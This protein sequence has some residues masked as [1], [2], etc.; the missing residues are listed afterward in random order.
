MK[1]NYLQF[2][3]IIAVFLGSLFIACSKDEPAKIL[4]PKEQSIEKLTANTWVLESIMNAGADVTDFHEELGLRNSVLK[5]SKSYEYTSEP[6]SRIFKNRGSWLLVDD[7]NL[8]LNIA[9]KYENALFINIIKG[10]CPKFRH[11]D[12]HYIDA[13]TRKIINN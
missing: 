1:I 10:D 7:R 8:K 2:P 12:R 9:T 6:S 3:Y 4:T 5:F 11:K 13:K